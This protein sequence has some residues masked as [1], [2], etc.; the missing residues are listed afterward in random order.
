MISSFGGGL[1]IT[2]GTAAVLASAF[3]G[4][5]DPVCVAFGD[6]AFV[7]RGS[8]SFVNVC[9]SRDLAGSEISTADEAVDIEPSGRHFFS[10]WTLC[11]E[12][13]SEPIVRLRFNLFKTGISTV[14]LEGESLNVELLGPVGSLL[15]G[16]LK[17]CMTD[18]LGFKE[19]EKGV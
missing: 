13:A 15:Q 2:A 9:S 12:V 17:I 19:P 1:A 4:L 6:T 10:K 14:G 5:K 11:G 18:S 8:D 16:S 3:E 7:D